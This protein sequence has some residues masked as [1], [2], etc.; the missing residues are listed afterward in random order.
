M[1]SI[2]VIFFSKNPCA[3]VPVLELDDGTYISEYSAII[4]YIDHTFEG[5]SL[6]ETSAKERAVIIMMQR[7]AESMYLTLLPLIFIMLLMV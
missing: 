1:L 6:T 3:S 7:R 5:I 2:E 4:E